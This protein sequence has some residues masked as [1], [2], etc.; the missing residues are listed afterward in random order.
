MNADIA[1][2]FQNISKAYLLFNRPQDR[3][4]ESLFK[5]FGKHYGRVFWALRDVSYQVRRGAVLGIIGRNGSGK[6]TLLQVIAGTLQPTAGL[7]AVNGRLSAL[8][9]LGAGFNPEFTGRENI[10]LNGAILGL[11]DKEVHERLDQIIAFAGI[12]EF[13]DQPVKIYSS[14]MYI[15]LAFAIA[16]SVDPDVLIIDEALAVGDAGFIIKCM[17]RMKQLKE[18]GTTILLVTHDVQTVRSFCDEA[19]WL[20]G[21]QVQLTGSPIDVTSHYVQYL[22]GD[23]EG[24]KDVRSSSLYQQLGQTDERN[25]IDLSSRPDLVRWGSGEITIASCWIYGSQQLSQPVFEHG[26]PIYVEMEAQVRTDIQSN[27][28]GVGMA[29]RNRKGLDIIVS[30]TLDQGVM[31]P[32]LRAGQVLHVSFELEN[33]LAPGEYALVLNVEDRQGGTPRYLDFVE[34]AIVFQV[35]SRHNIYSVVLPSV[36][37]TVRLDNLVL[38]N[39]I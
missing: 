8:L 32:T 38:G 33:I 22:F 6:S 16:A 5:Y 20:E 2:S 3:L 4:K 18:S 25:R 1:V 36:R 14:G 29:L 15:R 7:L 23:Q 13:V 11:T 31:L 21:G 24:M 17:N 12:G 27:A 28:L 37:Q 30:T 10:F 39:E 9:E 19:L 34:N 35:V 26:E